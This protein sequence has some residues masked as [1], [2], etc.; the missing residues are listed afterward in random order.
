MK[1]WTNW[2]DHH[3]RLAVGAIERNEWPVALALGL[4]MGA[5][6]AIARFEHWIN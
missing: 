6:Y 1:E 2:Q 5:L 3:R 4:I